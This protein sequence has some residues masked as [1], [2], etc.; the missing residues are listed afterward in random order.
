[1]F[2]IRP[3]IDNLS[4]MD[5]SAVNQVVVML[6]DLFPL[7][8]PEKFS[9]IP[10]LLNDP[11]KY[12]FQI[13]LFVADDFKGDVKGCA[14][15]YY[16]PDLSFCF[17]DYIATRRGIGSQ[18]IGGALYQRVREEA[19][20]MN[21]VGVF[22]ECLPDDPA[23]CPDAQILE[24]NKSRLK[25]YERYNARPIAG[26]LYETPVVADD[27]CAPYLVFDALGSKEPL[28]TEI[29]KPIVRA[30]LERK[31]GDYCPP[32]YIDR[33]VNSF[34]GN[35]V[36]LRKPMYVK[37]KVQ[38]EHVAVVKLQRIGMVVNHEHSIHHVK[39]RGYVEAPV[40]I[41]TILKEFSKTTL[42]HTLP[43]KGFPDSY[44]LEVHS[45][46]LVAYLKKVCSG[47][48][49]NQSVYP[50][51]FPI[52]NAKRLPNDLLVSAGY[53]CIDTFTP[54]SQNSYKAARLAVD[55]TLTAAE[56]LLETRSLAY[57]LVRPP[58]HHAETNVFGGFCY[59]NSAAV[60][61][62]LLSKY[63]RVAM[64]D[65]DY[66]H[67]NGQ[68][69]IFYLRNDVL[70]ISIHAE[71]AVAYPFF[72]GYRDEQGNGA[73]VGY[74]LNIPLPEKVTAMDYTA[75]LEKALASVKKFNPKFL[76]VCLGLDTAKGDPTGSWNLTPADFSRNGRFIG[77]LKIP[78]LVVQEG[79]YRTKSL[80]ANA[81]KF[82]SGM[83]EGFWN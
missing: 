32:D 3:V 14:I 28:S 62:N 67:G 68:Q 83:W 58:G 63:G 80:G 73:G 21:V 64:L 42:F 23:L 78:T 31:Y 36:V 20:Q 43:V 72:S 60:A 53:Y 15:L 30:I 27:T 59:F 46:S 75:A 11:L 37:S 50:Y 65:I 48:D 16:A 57:A 26:T 81:L 40:R 55:C 35:T 4:L 17:L 1:M 2:R 12:R 61:A 39:A 52:R 41:D 7:A 24:E 38:N 56:W 79:G 47:L 19:L 33:V 5:S 9:E 71:P 49:S 10:M 77:K 13:R 8:N 18:G 25:F 29:V 6:K 44:L 74:N 54:L 34:E 66:H 51:V 70:T 69:E 76:V 45:K 22:F 82:L